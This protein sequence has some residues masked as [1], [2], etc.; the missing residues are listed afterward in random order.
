MA[1]HAIMVMGAG[2]SSVLQRT[3][4][5]LDDPNIDFFIHW[6]RKFTLPK[7]ES[8]YS[9]IIFTPRISVTWGT[10]TQIR[11]I[12]LLLRAV[13]DDVRTY[14]YV[15]WISESDIPLMTK[16]YFLNYFTKDI[17]VGY[18]EDG[19]KC[20]S[21]ISYFWPVHDIDLQHH[22]FQRVSIKHFNKKYNIDRLQGLDIHPEKG[23]AWFSIKAKYISS[24][25]NWRYSYVFT[26]CHCAD[27]MY[28]QTFFADKKPKKLVEDDCTQ[29]ARYIDWKH[30][31]NGH[32]RIF[33]V[34]D[35]DELRQNMN[36]KYA[37]ARKIK[38]PH[39]ADAV[40]R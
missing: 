20:R 5:A 15:H 32:P 12:N 33:T 25:L 22:W 26:N 37:F 27:E 31:E 38:D 35:V 2:N 24:I 18:S 13:H 19:E 14:D 3:I 30:G 11:V 10:D 28:M 8:K 16:E 21:R 4:N 36:T 29:A 9:K 39:V 7:L 1:R 40:L 6:D 23:C 34:D 17:Y